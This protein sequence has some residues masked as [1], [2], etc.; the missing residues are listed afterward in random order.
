LSI[1]VAE[2]LALRVLAPEQTKG[3]NLLESVNFDAEP[4]LNLKKEL[5]T[6]TTLLSAII[7]ILIAGL[8]IRLSRL[9]AG[10]SNIKNEANEIFKTALPRE[11]NIVN[12]LAQLEQKLE[13]FR[14]YSHLFASLS[15]AAPTPLDVLLEISNQNPSQA[16]I[17]VD[18]ILIVDNTVRING[19]CDSFESVYQW[20]R[21]LEEATYFTSVDVEDVQKQ[22]N[23][24]VS[25]TMLLSSSIEELK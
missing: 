23:N 11:K 25:F 14:R 16:N 1:C 13:S 22:S 18:D 19:T 12:P 10:Y 9:E 21:L 24:I 20:Q 6:Y 7:I 8:F 17:E 4:A 2:G 5:V 15:L 3:I